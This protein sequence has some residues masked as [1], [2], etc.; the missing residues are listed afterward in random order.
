MY[1]LHEFLLFA[2]IICAVS[3]VYDLRTA[4]IPNWLTASGMIAALLG[5]CAVAY[6]AGGTSFALHAAESTLLGAAVCAAVPFLLWCLKLAGGGDVKL[7]A[8]VG[9]LCHANIGMESV[10]FA[11]ASCTAFVVVKHAWN[12][13]LLT[14]ATARKPVRF[15][16]AL[17]VGTALTVLVHGGMS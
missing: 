6:A 17:A 10:F 1:S 8:V 7:I 14:A 9:A 5:H 15:G 13:G 3:A 16:P 4:R 12:G 11:F 2:A